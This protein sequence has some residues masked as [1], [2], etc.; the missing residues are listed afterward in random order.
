[1]S[2]RCCTEMCRTVCYQVAYSTSM[3]AGPAPT[4]AS[5]AQPIYGYECYQP[6]GLWSC[7]AVTYGVFAHNGVSGYACEQKLH[8]SELK[9]E[10]GTASASKYLPTSQIRGVF[11]GYSCP[12]SAAF[13]K[14]PKDGEGSPVRSWRDLMAC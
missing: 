8:W 12:D 11:L 7:N 2:F 3:A 13:S 1:M 6:R 14:L 10:K 9:H 4:S 5:G